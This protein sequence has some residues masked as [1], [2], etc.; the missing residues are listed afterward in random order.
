VVDITVF[1]SSSELLLLVLTAFFAVAA[2]AVA[3]A[4]DKEALEEA[5][6][7]EDMDM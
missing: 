6:D 2:V 4:V 7:T 3:V 5:E 1:A